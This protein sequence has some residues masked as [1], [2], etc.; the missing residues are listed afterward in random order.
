MPGHQPHHRKAAR[1]LGAS[2]LQRDEIV[3]EDELATGL[4]ARVEARVAARGLTVQREQVEAL[5]R[6]SGRPLAMRFEPSLENFLAKPQQGGSAVHD[7]D[8]SFDFREGSQPNPRCLRRV[9]ESEMFS[10]RPTARAE[11]P[12]A[13]PIN[14]VK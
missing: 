1:R 13:R 7:L 12:S 2:G 10:C 14:C 8:C 11:S 4:P 6:V 3:V 5:A 9:I